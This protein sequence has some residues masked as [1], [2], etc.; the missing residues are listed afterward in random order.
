MRRATKGIVQDY[1]WDSGRAQKAPL[2]IVE[3]TGSEV[4]KGLRIK[5]EGFYGNE[6]T[7]GKV[8]FN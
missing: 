1:R 6:R 4:I 7:I 5:S 3:V 2:K 8:L